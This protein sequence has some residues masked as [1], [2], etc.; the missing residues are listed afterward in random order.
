MRLIHRI[1]EGRPSLSRFFAEKMI[2]NMPLEGPTL[3]RFIRTG[4]DS[5]LR[6]IRAYGGKMG[7][8]S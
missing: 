3:R 1:A 2:S 6:N 4:A 8:R 7:G 5:G